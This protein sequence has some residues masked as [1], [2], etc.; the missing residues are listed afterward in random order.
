MYKFENAS[1]QLVQ[2]HNEP[3]QNNSHKINIVSV[4]RGYNKEFQIYNIV[5]VDKPLDAK[6]SATRVL[7]SARMKLNRTIN[8]YKE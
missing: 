1:I 4:E 2:S 6:Y 7:L 8:C 3:Q 5:V